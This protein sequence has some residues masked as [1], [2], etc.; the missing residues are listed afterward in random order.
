MHDYQCLTEA[1]RTEVR[2]ILQAL[3]PGAQVDF[4]N[5]SSASRYQARSNPP[6]Y[7]VTTS[8]GRQHERLTLEQAVALVL[9]NA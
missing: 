9:E 8:P 1:H 2:E 3:A 7:V 6:Q 5:D 4:A